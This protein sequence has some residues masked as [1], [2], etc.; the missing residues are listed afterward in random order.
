MGAFHLREVVA[1]FALGAPP[2]AVC[3]APLPAGFPTARR[4]WKIL[5]RCQILWWYL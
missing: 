4:I 5:L 1:S 3:D 2:N